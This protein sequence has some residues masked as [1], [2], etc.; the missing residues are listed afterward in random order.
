MKLVDLT[1][2]Q[3]VNI[4]LR[5]DDVETR[6]RKEIAALQQENE[7]L[8]KVKRFRVLDVGLIIAVAC[9]AFIGLSSC[10]SNSKP[11]KGQIVTTVLIDSCQAKEDER[12]TTQDWCFEPMFDTISFFGEPI[13]M[14]DWTSIHHQIR[15]IA[16]ENDMLNYATEIDLCV[17]SI[18]EVEFGV[19]IDGDGIHLIASIQPD[20]PK[21]RHVI[22][23][24]NSIY[25]EPEEDDPDCYCWRAG[26]NGG[27]TDGMVI[28]L[29]PLHSEEGGTV[30]LF[31]K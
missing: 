19:N 18:G 14:D 8:V 10:N 31:G 25:G 6:L 3:L 4:I 21:M 7:R 26:A 24:L 27:C 23:Y 5:K 20:D 16:S 22:D 15:V 17:L 9:L 30:L 11:G 28:R 12:L 29:G 13:V 2:E 1:K